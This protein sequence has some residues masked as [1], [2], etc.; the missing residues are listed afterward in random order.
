MTVVNYDGGLL[1]GAPSGSFLNNSFLVSEA[2]ADCSNELNVINQRITETDFILFFNRANKYFMSSYKMPTTQRVQDY[3]VFNGVREYSL[4]TDFV[5]MMQLERP[6]ELDQQNFLH[7]TEK[8]FMRWMANNQTAYKFDM[9]SQL[10]MINFN[11]GDKMAIHNLNSVTDNGTWTLIGDGSNLVSDN[12]YSTDGNG[13]LKFGAVYAAGTATLTNSTMNTVDMT[14]FIDN[15]FI[16]TDVYNS[17]DTNL[18]SIK[19]RI[20]TDASNYYEMT[21][22]NRYNG[23]GLSKSYGQ[24]G[25]DMSSKTTTGAPTITNISYVQFI[26][27]IPVGYT[28]T[29]RLDNLFSANPVYFTLP[30][31][32]LYNVKDSSDNYK[33]KVTV[34]SDKIL[35][36]TEFYEAFT[37]KVCEMGAALKLGDQAEA[38]YF[39]NKFAEKEVELRAKFP[40]LEPRITTT[41][42]KNWNKF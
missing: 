9:E 2:I 42:F 28:G 39:M 35:C 18:T 41:Y 22:T 15:G 19:I 29:I 20:G 16:F 14:A 11:D 23:Q 21:A 31:Y 8:N 17:S 27:A 13:A 7:G 5:G 40:K 4:P 33:E 10:L 30:Y 32:S 3:L 6:Y 38:N 26:V 12:Q 37:Y 36:P 24:I 34:T 25:F 1:G